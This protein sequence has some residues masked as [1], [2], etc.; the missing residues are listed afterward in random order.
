MTSRILVT[1]ARSWHDDDLLEQWLD[2]AVSARHWAVTGQPVTV[3]HGNCPYGAD[4]LADDYCKARDITVERYSPAW[5]APCRPSCRPGH[6]RK[7]RH[8]PDYCPAA[9]MYRNAEMVQLGADLVLAFLMPCT[10]VWCPLTQPHDSH[11]TAGCAELAREAGLAVE[12]IR[13]GRQPGEE[14]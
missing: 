14:E 8:G 10:S 3:V 11:G 1:G 7:G 4:K 6:R 2:W 13:P 12:L 9:G 5:A